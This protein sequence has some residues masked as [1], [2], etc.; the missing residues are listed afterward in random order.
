M[1]YEY[2]QGVWFEVW[3]RRNGDPRGVS[4]LQAQNALAAFDLDLELGIWDLYAPDFPAIIARA[5]GLTLQYTARHGARTLDLLHV[6]TAL[7]SDSNEFLTFDG[8]QS[9]VAKAEGLVLL[10]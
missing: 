6:A 8:A 2:V 3:R 1:Q 9:E 4:E 10:A 7:E 5:E